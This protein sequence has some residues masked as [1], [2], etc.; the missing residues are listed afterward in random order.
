MSTR[1][2][3]GCLGLEGNARAHR[4][5][6]GVPSTDKSDVHVPSSDFLDHFRLFFDLC[7]ILLIGWCHYQRR[8][9]PDATAQIWP[10]VSVRLL[11]PCAV[12]SSTIRLARAGSLVA[13]GSHLAPL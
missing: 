9:T 2:S 4:L 7:V 12:Y 10:V 3:I 8:R 13:P 6:A 1:V 11:R 5:L